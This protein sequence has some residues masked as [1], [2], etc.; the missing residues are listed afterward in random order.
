MGAMEAIGG[1]VLVVTLILHSLI[2]WAVGQAWWES[3]DF[4]LGLVCMLS[5]LF[6]SFYFGIITKTLL[7]FGMF[8]VSNLRSD[9]LWFAYVIKEKTNQIRQKDMFALVYNKCKYT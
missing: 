5:P 6:F 8:L 7:Y 3:M 1:G 2:V 9:K 4:F